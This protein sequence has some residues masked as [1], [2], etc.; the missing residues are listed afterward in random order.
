MSQQAPIE[1]NSLWNLESV[2]RLDTGKNSDMYRDWL[3]RET[4]YF[5]VHILLDKLVKS[6]ENDE[7]PKF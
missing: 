7:N 1:K 3:D 6:N 4:N 2:N 5:F